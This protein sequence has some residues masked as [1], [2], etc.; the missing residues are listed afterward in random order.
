[1]KGN[2]F[3][4]YAPGNHVGWE[5]HH[6]GRTFEEAES[7]LSTSYNFTRSNLDPAWQDMRLAAHAAWNRVDLNGKH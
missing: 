4:F 3:A 7:E 2:K 1:M 5:G 6:D